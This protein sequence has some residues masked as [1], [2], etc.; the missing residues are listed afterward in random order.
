MRMRGL[1]LVLA[2]ATVFVLGVSG[3]HAFVPVQ[4][5]TQI[6]YSA[7]DVLGR[8]PQAFQYTVNRAIRDYAAPR[9]DARLPWTI[10]L[11]YN[12]DDYFGT[13]DATWTGLLA[14]E[15]PVNQW[16]WGFQAPEQY[17][18]RSGYDS[19]WYE[20]VTGYAYYDLDTYGR[21]GGF[22]HFNYAWSNVTGLEDEF[23]YGAGLFG[24]YRI[25]FSEAAWIT[26]TLTFT[27]YSPGQTNWDD[28]TI[29]SVGTRLDYAASANLG[30][31]AKLFY[32]ADT[33][34]DA[35]DDSY[36]DWRI[37]LNYLATD[38]IT[39]GGGVGTT[40]SFEDFDRTTFEMSV[41]MTF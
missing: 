9:L 26:P 12:S 38:R 19:L 25:N 28:S 36:L 30:L 33:S 7:D 6:Q 17:T 14:Y 2:L 20:G 27:Y 11:A 23:S 10:K 37:G 13:D 15:Q 34:N 35:I 3:A 32:N 41:R 40:E 29:F 18:D 8:T 24:S 21:I 1:V 39:I 16:G 22:G 4:L 31:W 5:Q